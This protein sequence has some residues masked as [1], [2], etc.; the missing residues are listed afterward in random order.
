MGLDQY[1]YEMRQG[2]TPKEVTWNTAESCY[3]RKAYGIRELLLNA[4]KPIKDYED[5]Y[6]ITR[7]SLIE[8][9]KTCVDILVDSDPNN[10]LSYQMGIDLDTAKSTAI[11]LL[12]VLPESKS[13]T[14]LYTES[15]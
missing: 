2:M 3:W 5:A 8:I 4:G 7:K 9:L 12:K 11:Q 1:L 6:I 15:Y 10:D 13:E 14:F